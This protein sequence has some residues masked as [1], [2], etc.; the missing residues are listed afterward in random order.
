MKPGTMSVS[1]RGEREG[2]TLPERAGPSARR[3]CLRNPGH[4]LAAS[5]GWKITAGCA[6]AASCFIK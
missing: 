6:G 4:L 1:P 2:H 3:G 5:N